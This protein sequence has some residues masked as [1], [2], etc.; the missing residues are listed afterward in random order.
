MKILI[1]STY[2][3][4]PPSTG[5]VETIVRNTATELAKKGHEVHIVCSPLDVTTQKPMTGLGVEERDGVVV[6]KMKPSGFRVGYARILKGLKETIVRI[7]PDIV[8]AHNLH[9]HLFQLARWKNRLRYKLVAELHY[10]AVNLDFIVQRMLLRPTMKMLK[11]VS[12]SIDAFIAHTQLEKAWLERHGIESSK[13]VVLPTQHIRSALLDYEAPSSRNNYMILFLSR[14]VPKKGVHVLIKAFHKVK[15]RI[16][17][18][19]LMIAGSEDLKYKK[20]LLSLVKELN[21]DKTVKFVGPVNEEE[22]F[23]LMAS[24]R[25]FCLPTLADY[26][27]IVLLEA[28]ALGTPVVSTKVGAIPEI[29]LD[30]ETGILVKPNNSCELAK[31]IIRLIE[32]EELWKRLSAKARKWAKNF[33]LEE[34]VGELESFYREILKCDYKVWAG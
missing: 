7:R 32:D 15:V 8:H 4:F 23:R 18:A 2:Y 20:R 31:A 10:P 11:L 17:E 16:P 19:E 28:Q 29:V 30:R 5:G 9:L 26:H 13:I 3:T 21:L 25:V 24:A 1:V 14:I 6:H 22:K 12:N 33:T 34:Q 27:P